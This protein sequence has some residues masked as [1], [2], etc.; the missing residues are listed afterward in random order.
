MEILSPGTKLFLIYSTDIEN[1]EDLLSDTPV[2]IDNKD[3]VELV[4]LFYP[5]PF[6]VIYLTITIVNVKKVTV[7]FY[8]EQPNFITEF[9]ITVSIVTKC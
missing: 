5:K 9:P 8:Q 3:K 4:P 1:P 2:P 7:T 6:R